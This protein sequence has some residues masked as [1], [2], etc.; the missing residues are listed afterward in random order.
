[1]VQKNNINGKIL[2]ICGPT[3]SGKSALAL[4]CAKLLDSEI[5]YADSMD[6]YKTLDV[7]TAKP[8][9]EEQNIVKHHLIDVV[10]PEEE[11][12]VSQYKAMAEPIINNLLNKGKIPVVCGGTGFYINSILYDLSYGGGKGDLAIREKYKVLVEEKGKEYVFNILKEKDPITAEKL[13]YNDVK[14]VIR[15]LEICDSGIKKS[16]IKDDITPKYNYDAYTIDFEREKLYSRINTRVDL[17]VSLGLVN[18]VKCLMN[19][20]IT[21][22]NQCMQGI[23]YKEIYSYLQGQITLDEAVDLIKLNTRHYAK[24]Q[25]TFF[26]R[27][28]NI[29]NLPA[30]NLEIL[31]KRIIDNLWTYNL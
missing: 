16:D 6:I 26:K 9:K 14:R 30:E 24:R 25:I 3:A 19:K 7:G 28:P 15:A 5:V 22:K 29:V 20:G 17:M 1:M 31:A 21:L 2:I 12:S 10:S 13:H 23:G 27:M 18:E 8:T 4:E 11:F